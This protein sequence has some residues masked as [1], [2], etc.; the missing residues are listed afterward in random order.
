MTSELSPLVATAIWRGLLPEWRRAALRGEYAD[1]QSEGHN[2]H[3]LAEQ[4]VRVC[5]GDP[6][7][8]LNAG[9]APPTDSIN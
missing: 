4:M 2:L 3:A 8:W 1:P 9:I 6:D 7:F 5:G